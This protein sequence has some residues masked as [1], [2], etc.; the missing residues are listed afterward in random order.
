M[1]IEDQRLSSQS[2]VLYGFFASY[3]WPLTSIVALTAISVAAFT[4]RLIDY[5]LEG[6]WGQAATKAFEFAPSALN[7]HALFGMA[8]IP[9][10]LLQPLLGMML[11]DA[12]ASDSVRVA[13]R[14]H[15]RLLALAAGVLSLLGLYITYR[16]AANSDSVTSVIFML[17]VALFVILFFAQAV[18]EARKHRISRHLDALVFAMIFLSVP[19]T[20]RL[21]EAFMRTGG[22]E[23]TRSKDLLSIGYGYQVEL[24]DITILLVAAVPIVLWSIYAIPRSA[25]LTHPAK[26]WVA[27]LF[28]GLPLVAVVAQT[29]NR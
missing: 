2:D 3:R 22:V 5:V 7:T 6:H 24:V 9:L 10:F 20:G 8:L 12:K 14:W 23:N 1:A 19:A 4:P 26:L 16:F 25:V 27:S 17:L 13:H 21:I 11:M 29:I 18:W 15:G 28:L